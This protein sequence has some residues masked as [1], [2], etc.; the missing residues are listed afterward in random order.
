[1]YATAFIP[2]APRCS[3]NHLDTLINSKLG[4]PGVSVGYE[5]RRGFIHDLIV[6]SHFAFPSLSCLLSQLLSKTH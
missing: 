4:L 2:D 1:M 5:L 3:A 6:I